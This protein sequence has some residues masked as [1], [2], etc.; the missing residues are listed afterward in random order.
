MPPMIQA[1]V[2]DVQPFGLGWETLALTISLLLGALIAQRYR[3]S[4][5]GSQLSK[6]II[7][8]AVASL[9]VFAA[10]LW[11][12]RT[13]PVPLLR[14]MQVLLLTW[15]AVRATAA[16]LVR[17][18]PQSPGLRLVVSL[19]KWVIWL[20]G[21]M[22]VLG[23]IAP[24]LQWLD[25]TTL[26]FGKPPISLRDI[27]EAVVT[28]VFTLLAALWI[29]TA[30]ETQLMKTQAIDMNL[31]LVLS[32]VMRAVMLF[33]AVLMAMSV[34][35][36]PIAALSVFGGALGVGLGLGLQRL[37]ANYV[38]GFVILLDGS[39]KVNDNI[40]VEGFDG[41]VTAIRTRYTLVKALNG[42]ESIVPNEM[43]VNHR[44]EN[45]SLANPNVLVSMVL[46]CAYESEVDTALQ[47]ATDAALKQPRVLQDPAPHTCIS[48]FAAD[49]LELTLVFWIADPE[50]G[51]LALK[52]DIFRE[53]LRQF[54][55]KGIEV[56]YP[57]RV[58][59]QL[60]QE[61]T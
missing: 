25:E 47:I 33:I 18:F 11:L 55:T 9:A 41:Q 17:A 26:P 22:A 45:L 16:L 48:A 2:N 59:R 10:T 15:L 27:V 61:A 30:L 32:K 40:R 60:P 8:P 39:I 46:S 53:I 24:S 38:S 44:V 31:R 4:F 49:G 5:P 13:E 1:L 42:R 54:K 28:A 43:L 51:Q 23:L 52:G 58:L 3:A 7:S 21:A 35:G 19:G 12:Q 57:Q 6:E 50:Q 34:A 56:P 29:S 36:I 14:I 20:V 37:A